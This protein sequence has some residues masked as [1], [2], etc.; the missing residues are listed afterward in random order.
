MN[1]SEDTQLQ[2]PN[3]MGRAL[4]VGGQEAGAESA[5][6]ALVDGETDSA[7]LDALLLAVAAGQTEA[8][9]DWLSYHVIGDVLRGSAP[10]IPVR[11]SQAFLAEFQARLQS[12]MHAPNLHR[13]MDRV[14]HVRAPAANDAVF[15]WKLVAGAASL[16]AVMAVSWSVLGG[17]PGGAGGSGP[18]GPQMALMERPPQEAV[19]APQ[20]A[21]VVSTAQGPVIRDPRLEALLAEHRQYGGMSALQMPAGFLRDATYDAAPQR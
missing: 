8:Q 2:F 1:A 15:R 9:A 6:S 4:Q 18:A 16:A 3:G 12:E 21:V 14:E 11:S 20:T 13:S 10:A 17:A 5:L 7:E 19:G